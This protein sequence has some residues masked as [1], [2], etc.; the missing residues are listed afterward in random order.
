MTDCVLP[1]SPTARLAALM[2]LL[3]VES[4]TMRPPQTASISSS[5]PTTRWRFLMRVRRRL[6]TWG[7]TSTGPDPE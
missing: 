1:L 7:S 3:N 4:E 2:R 5:F 6:N